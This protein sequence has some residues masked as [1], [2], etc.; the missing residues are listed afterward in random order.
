MPVNNGTGGQTRGGDID[1]YQRLAVHTADVLIDALAAVPRL[2]I[3][4][5]VPF[6][7][8]PP[9]LRPNQLQDVIIVPRATAK[10]H[11]P[12]DQQRIAWQSY[13]LSTAVAHGGRIGAISPLHA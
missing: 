4:F 13:G 11:R 2:V 12:A 5:D 8:L 10:I 9:A 3:A 6:F 7:G 1:A